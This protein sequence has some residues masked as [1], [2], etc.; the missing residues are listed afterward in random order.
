MLISL[1]RSCALCPGVTLG[2]AS[3]EDPTSDDIPDVLGRVAELAARH[4][5]AQAVV[6]DADVIVDDAVGEVVA[7]L[8]H[9]PD[10]DADALRVPQV[11]D[12]VLDPHHRRV[13]AQRDLPAARRQMVGDRVPDHPQQLL[14]RVGRSDRESVQQLHHQTGEALERA[15]DADGRADL[16]EDALGRVDVDLKLARL[17]DG[18]VQQRQETLAVINGPSSASRIPSPIPLSSALRRWQARSSLLLLLLLLL[19]HLMSDVRPGLADVAVHLAHDPDV[20]IAVEQRVLL[21]PHP[22]RFGPTVRGLEGFQAR[23]RQHN[24]Q[25]LGVPIIGGDGHML[26]GDELGKSRRR[27]RLRS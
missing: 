10:E 16:D 12:V 14:L 6:A 20:L 27:A 8:G 24:N 18:R 13:E 5:G 21:I 25:A 9:R 3:T 1:S 15:R 19:P 17:V 22:A 26:L 11:G 2:P 4:A 23:I 7:S